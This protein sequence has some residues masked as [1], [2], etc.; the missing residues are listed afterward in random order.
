M[1]D[2]LGYTVR[3]RAGMR[4]SS[5]AASSDRVS[6]LHNSGCV[7]GGCERVE[8]VTAKRRSG[9]CLNAACLLRY[10]LALGKAEPSAVW[11]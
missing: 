10:G 1:R 9:A 7:C 6:V 5:G 2:G 4:H 8:R 3:R 11:E